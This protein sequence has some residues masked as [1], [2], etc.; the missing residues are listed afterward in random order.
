[1]LFDYSIHI[2]LL[3][4]WANDVFCGC[5]WTK[6]F[7]ELSTWMSWQFIIQTCSWKKKPIYFR[8]NSRWAPKKLYDCLQSRLFFS[9]F[10]KLL[11]CDTV[12]EWPFDTF[13]LLLI[14]WICCVVF[15]IRFWVVFPFCGICSFKNLT[16]LHI[17]TIIYISSIALYGSLLV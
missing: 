5:C 13:K 17:V 8:V 4:S 10:P 9:H 12:D 14:L 2:T 6:R 3:S 16:P 7:C 11:T 1:M 15:Y